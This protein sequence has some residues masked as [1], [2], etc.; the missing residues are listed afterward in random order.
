VPQVP[1]WHNAGR[2][3]EE[4]VDERHERREGVYDYQSII[5][6]L[7]YLLAA[8]LFDGEIYESEVTKNHWHF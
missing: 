5:V 6:G 7:L 4:R 3:G 1:Q 8:L 2:K